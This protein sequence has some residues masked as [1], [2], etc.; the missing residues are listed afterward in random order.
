MKTIQ[1]RIEEIAKEL[2]TYLKEDRETILH[3]ELERNVIY[4]NDIWQVLNEERPT[5]FN[6]YLTGEELKTPSSLA[7]SI[8][9]EAFYYR[10][11]DMV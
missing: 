8:L 6:C 7:Y 4:Y 5:S 10:F 3:E 11:G 1:E 9:L 2:K